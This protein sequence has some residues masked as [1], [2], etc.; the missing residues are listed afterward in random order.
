MAVKALHLSYNQE[1]W[2]HVVAQLLQ[3]LPFP[4]EED[5]LDKAKVIDNFY[6]PTRYPSG[7]AGGAPYHHYGKYQSTEAIRYAGEIIEFVSHHLAERK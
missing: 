6:I 7:H 2:G 5:L 3:E 4:V 1:A